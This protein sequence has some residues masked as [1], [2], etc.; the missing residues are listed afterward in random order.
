MSM[1]PGQ[2]SLADAGLVEPEPAKPQPGDGED[3]EPDL[4]R[5]DLRG[6]AGEADVAEQ[7]LEGPDD[8]VDDYPEA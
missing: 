6:E 2:E 8:E 3:Y 1:V 4:P 7:E 5:P